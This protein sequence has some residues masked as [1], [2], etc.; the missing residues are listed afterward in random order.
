M[1]S[2]DSTIA[3]ASRFMTLRTGDIISLCRTPLRTEPVVGSSLTA[4]LNG[5]EILNLK[6]R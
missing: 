2:T 4:T 3:L 5:R 1:L 6:L